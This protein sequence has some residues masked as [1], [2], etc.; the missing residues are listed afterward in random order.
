MAHPE[1]I[2]IS[3]LS[4]DPDIKGSVQDIYKLTVAGGKYLLCRTSESG[5][6]FDVGTIFSVPKS[7]VLRTAIRHFIY[8]RLQ[9]PKTWQ[10]LDEEDIRAC[11]SDEKVLDDLINGELWGH[12]KQNGVS[13]HHVGM[14]DAGTGQVFPKEPPDPLSSLVLIEEFPIYHPRRFE[15]WGRFGWDYHEY[16]GRE[17]KVLGL[18][19]VF[20]LGNPGGSSL[21][22]RYDSALKK[23]GPDKAR[24]LL[25]SMGI[26]HDIKPWCD[27]SNMIYDCTSKYEPQDRH[28]DW[29]ETIHISGVPGEQF[30]RVARTLIFCT[31]YVRKFFRELGFKL[32]DIK[33]E[34]AVDRDRVV[35][36]D[37]IDP[38]SIRIT[39]STDYEGM[40][41]FVHFNKQSV[42]DYYKIVHGDWY[43]ALNDAK[44]RV[45]TDSLGRS[46]ME[47]YR[48]GVADGDYPDI[49]EYDQDFGRIQSRKYAVMVEPLVNNQPPGSISEKVGEIM[50]DEMEFY[51]NMGK[52][53]QLL[54]KNS[55]PDRDGE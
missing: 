50:R 15:L 26:E 9:N 2:D 20:R 21:Q 43:N 27:L 24:E 37:T 34:V 54:E 53:D 41:C 16:F 3:I 52:L 7:D 17:K 28:L 25:R 42:R 1:K 39:G 13:T 29:Q 10:N 6:V 4:G 5:S 18:E 49:P 8:T 14:V 19:N 32:W 51:K 30:K 12:L 44:S 46:F 11:Y 36:V 35:V 47:I 48:Q 31:I 22:M 55:A 33:W 38:D 40:R 45:E 23:G